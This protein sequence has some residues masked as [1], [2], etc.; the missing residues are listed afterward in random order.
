MGGVIGDNVLNVMHGI[1]D[2]KYKGVKWTEELCGKSSDKGGW[3][4]QSDDLGNSFCGETRGYLWQKQKSGGCEKSNQSK[5]GSNFCDV[6]K[7]CQS[8][9]TQGDFS[10]GFYS[11]VERFWGPQEQYGG[12]RMKSVS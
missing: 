12:M 2:A 5:D 4:H 8:A 11:P 10:V 1:I 7:S 3:Y 6:S 9:E